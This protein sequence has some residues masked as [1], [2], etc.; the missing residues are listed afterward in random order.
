MLYASAIEQVDMTYGHLCR[1]T[2]RALCESLV[3]MFNEVVIDSI[4]VSKPLRTDYV[5]I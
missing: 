5:K 1:G 2:M 3:V 4:R